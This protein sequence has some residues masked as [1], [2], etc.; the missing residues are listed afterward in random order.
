MS[1]PYCDGTR[2]YASGFCKNCGAVLDFDNAETR[3][4]W[5][6]ALTWIRRTTDHWV[7]SPEAGFDFAPG[8]EAMRAEAP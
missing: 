6:A 7:T 4:R 1:C 5:I 2:F 8:N 3:E